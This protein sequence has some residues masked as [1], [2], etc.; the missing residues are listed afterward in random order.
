MCLNMERKRYLELCQQSAI[1]RGVRVLYKGIQYIPKGYELRFD[2]SGS[3]IHRAI[4]KDRL[5]N[6]LIYCKLEEVFE[7]EK[8]G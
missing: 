4:L 3:S 5:A 8:K 7:D 1:G 6:S 2:K